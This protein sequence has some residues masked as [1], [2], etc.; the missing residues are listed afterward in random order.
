MLDHAPC[1]TSR[2]RASCRACSSRG[3]RPTG[4]TPE[5]PL[6]AAAAAAA[7]RA[8]RKQARPGHCRGPAAAGRQAQ[9]LSRLAVTLRSAAARWRAPTFGG[10]SRVDLL[11]LRDAALCESSLARWER[12]SGCRWRCGH[13]PLLLEEEKQA[14]GAQARPHCSACSRSMH[15]PRDRPHLPMHEGDAPKGY[16]DGGA[17]ACAPPGATDL[18]RCRSR[19]CVC[20]C[21]EAVFVLPASAPFLSCCADRRIFWSRFCAAR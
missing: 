11:S 8:Q 12:R 6:P 19:G 10:C 5:A 15:S 3:S 1:R 9:P 16:A 2:C 17:G 14:L 20:A 13:A 4:C 18:T 7:R 21:C